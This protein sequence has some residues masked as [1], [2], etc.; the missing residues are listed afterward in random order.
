MARQRER[1]EL[2]G[3]LVD[4]VDVAGAVEQLREFLAMANPTRW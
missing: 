1:I 4:R 2:G 3:V